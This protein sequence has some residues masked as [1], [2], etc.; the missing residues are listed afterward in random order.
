MVT[1]HIVPRDAVIVH[2]IQHT[3]ARLVGSIDVEFG[4]V[5]LADFL[6]TR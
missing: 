2:V 3:H 1:G 4:I 6:V 5:G